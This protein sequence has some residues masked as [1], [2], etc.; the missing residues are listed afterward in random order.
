MFGGNVLDAYV[1]KH[2]CNVCMLDCSEFVWGKHFFSIMNRIP[3]AFVTFSYT[4]N[5]VKL[6][7]YRIMFNDLSTTPKFA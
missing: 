5:Q 2:V 3:L 7:A 6:E 4:N 1:Y